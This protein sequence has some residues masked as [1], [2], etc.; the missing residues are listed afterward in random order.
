MELTRNYC[1]GEGCGKFTIIVNKKYCL[2][3]E[4][5]FKRLHDGKSKQETYSARAAGKVV[6]QFRKPPIDIENIKGVVKASKLKSISDQKKFR[7]SDGSLVSQVEIKRRYAETCDK[8]KQTRPA[9]CEGS[10]RWDVPLSFSHT[11][12]QADCKALG[13]TELIWDERNIELEGFEAPTS[14]PDMAHNIW[15]VG[16]MEDKVMLLNF[17]R[18]VDF[19]KIHDP[20]GYQNIMNQ[21]DELEEKLK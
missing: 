13:K 21:L 12:S 20:E 6:Q 7:C 19:I 11:I 14:R 9:M 8:I 1:K 10:G 17:N 3:D 4:C 2:C 18:K 5:N 16:A 15:E